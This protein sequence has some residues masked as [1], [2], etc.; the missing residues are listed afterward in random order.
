M[1]DKHEKNQN[2]TEKVRVRLYVPQAKEGKELKLSKEQIRHLKV[3]RVQ[4]GQKVALFDG[5]GN[6]FEAFLTE[7]VRQDTLLCGK[8]I[9]T[10]TE[11]PI[12]ITL[13]CAA[14]KGSRMDI[15]IEKVSELGVFEVIPTIYQRSVVEPKEGKIER[16]RKIAI[17]ACAQSER[18]TIPIISETKKFI[19]VIHA[20]GKFKNKIIC[21]KDGEE[22]PK[23]EGDA[24]ILIGPEGD[25][26]Q[27]EIR[28]AKSE[29]FTPVS[30]APSVLRVETAAITAMA[31]ALLK[32]Q[33]L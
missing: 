22:M 33:D 24:I 11:P 5:Q 14:P 29:G 26:T 31:Q 23:L 7:K 13:A 3:L 27:D 25:F 30:L 28:E 4:E 8:R 6:S 9:E 12:H 16:L 10:A 20:S 15:L 1:K 17:E 2:H 21:H 32:A 19:D 18:N